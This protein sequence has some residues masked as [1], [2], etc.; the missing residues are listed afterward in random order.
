MLCVAWGV[1]VERRWYRLVRHRLDILPAAGDGP[2]SLT[3]LHLS[4]LH[5]VAG[6]R[7]KAAFLAGL[8]RADVTI[9]TGDF[10]AEPQAVETAV[11]AVEPLRGGWP[12]GSCWDRTTT[13]SRG[14]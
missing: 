9:V 14:P 2:R 3:I 7:R 12:P 1:V 8:P 6:D 4:D 13:S 11:A 5:F 10:L